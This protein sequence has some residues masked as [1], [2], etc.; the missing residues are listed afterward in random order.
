MRAI[1][2]DLVEKRLWPVAVL[3]VVALVAVPL[4]LAKSPAEPAQTV[5]TS[6]ASEPDAPI[7]SEPAVSVVAE[8]AARK[9]ALHGRVKN[10][11]HQQHVPPKSQT[12]DAGG[13][14]PPVASTTPAGTGTPSSGGGGSSGGAPS[15]PSK[16]QRTY[17]VATIDVRFGPT[18]GTKHT[19]ADVLRLRALPRASKPIAIFMGM[20]KDLKTAVFLISSDV[21]ARGDGTC[22]PSRA[23]CTTIELKEGD[24]A[25]LDVASAS[26]RVTQYELDLVKVTVSHT[27]SKSDAQEAYARV[28]RAGARM[29]ARRIRVSASNAAAGGRRER[30]PYRYAVARGVLHIAPFMTHRRADRAHVS[31]VVR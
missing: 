30:I 10:P 20:R 6:A 28:S 23:V 8:P 24:V 14:T 22:A 25:L 27:T 9:G 26:G 5:T 17:D 19:Y 13:G 2:S 29:L 18:L 1:L 16:P 21:H 11:F 31:S 12:A 7:A 15:T 3:L 4:V